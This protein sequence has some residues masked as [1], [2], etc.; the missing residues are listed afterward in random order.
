M[1][2]LAKQEN[3]HEKDK[4]LR[5]MASHFKRGVRSFSNND[6]GRFKNYYAKEYGVNFT[7]DVDWF[8]GL[9][10]SEAL[11]YDDRAYIANHFKFDTL[12]TSPCRAVVLF[13]ENLCAPKIKSLGC[14]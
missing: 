11:V 4:I 6:F 9:L 3:E 12:L 5:L 2:D 1:C 8:N 7:Y 14:I 13:I 10:E